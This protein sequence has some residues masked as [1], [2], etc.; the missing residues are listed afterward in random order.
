M[1]K[2]IDIYKSADTK[3]NGLF[4]LQSVLLESISSL[5]CVDIMRKMNE[6]VDAQIKAVKKSFLPTFVFSL[7]NEN[8]LQCH[9]IDDTNKEY[10]V[11]SFSEKNG[12]LIVNEIKEPA[13]ISVLSLDELVNEKNNVVNYLKDKKV[14]YFTEIAVL[15]M[16]SS[17]ITLA[18]RLEKDALSFILSNDKH[19]ISLRAIDA[20]E[21][22]I[23][24]TTVPLVVVN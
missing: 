5:N 11:V 12:A 7:T 14:N 21:K 18:D 2:V 16:F 1:N 17:F 8:H 24:E 10:S 4:E 13:L 23:M 3:I 19:S 22:T 9:C 6:I 15:A 20:Y